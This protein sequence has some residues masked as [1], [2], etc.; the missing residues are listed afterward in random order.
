VDELEAHVPFLQ[1]EAA[2][3]LIL[4]VENVLTYSTPVPT[5]VELSVSAELYD[6][7]VF[8]EHLRKELGH[9]HIEPLH[10]LAGVFEEKSGV[11]SKQL[12]DTGVTQELVLAKLREEG[13]KH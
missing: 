10:L 1:P 2:A 8:A 13:E 5:S 11:Y 7:F 6:V 9:E 4:S 3:R 12:R